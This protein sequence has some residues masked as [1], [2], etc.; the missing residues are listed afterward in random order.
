[1]PVFDSGGYAVNGRIDG[2]FVYMLLCGEGD[3]IYVKIGMSAQPTR[4]LM[5]LV[6]NCPVPAQRFATANTYS[7][8]MAYAVERALHRKMKHWRQQGEWFRLEHGDKEE[9][10]GIWKSV[11]TKFAKPHWPL[12]W[13]QVPVQPIVRQAAT[14]SWYWRKKNMRYLRAA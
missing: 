9:F 2:A 10:N 1:M 13:V 12:S 3:A 11:F 14:R 4:R 7:R 8:K 6:N 5:T